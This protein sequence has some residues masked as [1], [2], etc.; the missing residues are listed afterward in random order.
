MGASVAMPNTS[1]LTRSLRISKQLLISRACSAT[2]HKLGG[3]ARREELPR[4][5]TTPD[6]VMR[7]PAVAL[8][9]ANRREYFEHGCLMLPKFITDEWIHRL[10][11]AV[12][13]LMEKSRAFTGGSADVPSGDQVPLEKHFVLGR[14]HCAQRLRITRITSPVELGGIFREFAFGP[15]ADIA[16][17]LLGPDVRL[18]HSKLN[19]KMGGAEETKVQWHQDIQFWPHSNYTP[20]TIGVYLTDVD[21]RMGPMDVVPLSAYDQL[22]PLEDADGNWTGVLPADAL[23]AVPWDTARRMMGPAGTVTVHNARCV[24]GGAAN[25]TERDRLLLLHTF[26]AATAHPLPFGT[27]PLHQKSKLGMPMV[28]GEPTRLAVFDPRPCPMAPSFEAGYRPPFFSRGGDC[29]DEIDP[30]MD[31]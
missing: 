28:R 31:G 20:L 7:W 8:S 2:P 30:L 9:D 24:H 6:E 11:G 19:L 27:N 15:L 4:P 21:E 14:G 13:D 23:Q 5:A 17:D 10:S 25:T 12:E 18:H 16:Q 1:G 26:V 29:T 22:H 3:N